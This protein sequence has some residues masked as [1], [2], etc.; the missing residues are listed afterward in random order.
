MESR[1][2]RERHG[3]NYSM[4]RSP[5]AADHF[6]A[7]SGAAK[8]DCKSWS[9]DPVH[10]PASIERVGSE[11]FGHNPRSSGCAASHRQGA[12]SVSRDSLLSNAARTESA[13]PDSIL[14]FILGAPAT[15]GHGRLNLSPRGLSMNYS[16]FAYFLIL[17]AGTA[18]AQEPAFSQA[19]AAKP[20]PTAAI[21][22]LDLSAIDKTADPCTDFYQYACGNW[23]KNNPLPAD[24]VRWGRFTLLR[25]RNRYLL[26]QEVDA[27]AS[28]P[29]T[30]LQ[31][32]YGDFYA[33]CMDT[34]TVEKKGLTPIQPA[35]TAIARIADA[36]ELPALLGQ[37][38][39][40]GTP[41][42]FFDFG[43]DIDEKD[44]SKQIA[45]LF[46]GGLSLPDRD[47]YL[48]D[49]PHFKEIRAQYVDH[50]KKM[51]TLAGDAPEQ[52][53]KEAAAVLEIET[54][55]AKASTSRTDLRQPENRYH[56]QTAGDFEKATPAFDWGAYF[57]AIGIG[58]FD[59]LN[60][61]TPEFFKALSGLIQSEPLASWKSYLRWQSLHGQA[62]N[63]PKAFFD[64]NF[65]FFSGTLA[66]Q[67]EPQARWKQC[68]S[69]TDR[70]HG[71]AVGQD[72]VK[73]TFP[74]AAKDSMDRLVAS[75][76]KS[77]GDDIKTLP[78]MTDAT[79][80]SAAEKLAM[81]RNKI[82]YPEKWRDYSSVK[83]DRTDL[84][85][86]LH[87]SAVYERNYNFA[88]LG[89]PVDEKEWGMTPP[90]VNA[91]YS[92]SFNDINFPAGILQ[93]PFFDFTMDP[94]LNFGGIGVVIGHEMTHGFDDQ[95]SKYDGKGNLREWQTAE[96]REAFTQRTECVASEYSGFEV[97]PAHGDV[98]AQ[99]L[100]GHLTL[101][102]N[103]ADNGGL[104]IAYMA[105]L[106][107]LAA[108]GKSTD[109]KIDGYTEAQR[110][111]LGFGQLW[112]MNQT[113]QSARQA[114]LTDPHS[115]AKWRV[116]GTVQNFDAFGKAF[117][118]AKGQPMV[119]A[120]SCRV[121]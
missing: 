66:G 35:W 20:T 118:C 47:Y 18:L 87:R 75:L 45:R 17:A 52:A 80:Q 24:Q 6:N 68:T 26:W 50:M 114:A 34:D 16:R 117:G 71:E 48:E 38:E 92:Q 97:A 39:N 115:A 40:H 81:I 57:S 28:N 120:N 82:G 21:K 56:V 13:A 11:I 12:T 110:Y 1:S 79:K 84:I 86:N 106:D 15:A 121:W 43:V 8:R 59:T 2:S 67:K 109:D 104:R 101:G 98:A 64:E 36:K 46:Q 49:T 54:A 14:A 44:S 65:D 108:Q 10:R 63:L 31:K 99:K 88:K 103:T 9:A 89:K 105:L 111:F 29:K 90:T 95:G 74:P 32:Q 60:V 78:W 37:L 113:E 33:A 7:K 93:P 70:A 25:E 107:T 41:D 112:C 91:Y 61:A 116:N 73:L 102:E 19:D 77:L 96:D 53:A 30:P 119:P 62:E 76:E 5:C 4:R 69:M 58:R 94:A 55:L 72:W 42:G 27:A 100:N 85:G 23:V 22:S 51:F 3:V 83:V